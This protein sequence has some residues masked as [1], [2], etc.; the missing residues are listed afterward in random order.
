[1]YF[2][3]RKISYGKKNIN[4]HTIDTMAAIVNF[5]TDEAPEL[6]TRHLK[7][8]G[9]WIGRNSD[10]TLANRNEIMGACSYN[11]AVAE[12]T[13]AVLADLEVKANALKGKHGVVEER[14]RLNERLK[15]AKAAANVAKIDLEESLEI[16]GKIDE[17]NPEF[18]TFLWS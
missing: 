10:R 2:I 18:V 11:K 12:R 15:I 3:V 13:E 9:G 7:L 17:T 4:G 16:V 8:K 1:M 5:G 6:A 14:Q